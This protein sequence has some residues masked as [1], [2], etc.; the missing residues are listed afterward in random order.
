MSELVVISKDG[1][2]YCNVGVREESA[3]S[4]NLQSIFLTVLRREDRSSL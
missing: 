1:F 4:N 2:P 3:I